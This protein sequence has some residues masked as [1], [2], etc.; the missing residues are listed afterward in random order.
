M[1]ALSSELTIHPPKSRSRPRIAGA[2][3]TIAGIRPAK[4]NIDS[5]QCHRIPDRDEI[6]GLPTVFVNN[7]G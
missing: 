3:L 7:P 6:V 1:G 2:N 4:R 5:R